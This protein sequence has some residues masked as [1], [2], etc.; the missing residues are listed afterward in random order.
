[1]RA[2]FKRWIE[3]F[4]FAGIGLSVLQIVSD[5]FGVQTRIGYIPMGDGG[6]V[7]DFY[8]IGYCMVILS[9]LLLWAMKELPAP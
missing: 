4:G 7:V 2:R 9:L 1:M 8:F 5:I 6:Q 3:Y